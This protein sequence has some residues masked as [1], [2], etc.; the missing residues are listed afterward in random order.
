MDRGKRASPLSRGRN[1][2]LPCPG[3]ELDGAWLR[4]I[5]GLALRVASL[6]E[7]REGIGR[8]MALGAGQEF[9]GY[10]PYREGE[11]LRQFDWGLLARLGKPFVRTTRRETSERWQVRLDASRSM[12]CGPPGKLQAAAELC[13]GL[14]GIA[15]HQGAEVEVLASGAAGKRRFLVRRRADLMGLV[16]FLSDLRAEDEGGMQQLLRAGRRSHGFGRIFLLGDLFDMEPQDV[17]GLLA[18]GREIY[19]LQIL[20]PDELVPA[21]ESVDWR[22][23]EGD[24]RR[25]VDLDRSTHAHYEEAL[26]RHLQ[27]WHVLAKH[28]SVNHHLHP[29]DQDFTDCLTKVLVP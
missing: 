10:R 21:G 23:P 2:P 11:D 28:A 15:L 29:S 1:L 6:E 26:K 4:R 19:L 25:R 8:R 9:M 22:D 17:L 12:A 3:V 20:S 7:R 13:G 24:G 14:V 27:A 5:E 18:P 16:A